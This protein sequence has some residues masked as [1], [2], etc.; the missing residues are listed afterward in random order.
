MLKCNTAPKGIRMIASIH[1][2]HPEATVYAVN[3]ADNDVERGHLKHMTQQPDTLAD[4]IPTCALLEV[5]ECPSGRSLHSEP[6][7]SHWWSGWPGAYCMKCGDEDKME[8]CLAG[9][10]CHCHTAF[11][12]EY[13][14]YA[15]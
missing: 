12:E 7:A 8:I 15:S 6:L 2:K 10:L 13:A 14:K 1:I 9:C 5:R 4:H 3:V 11:W